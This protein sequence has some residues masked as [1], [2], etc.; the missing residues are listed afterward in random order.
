MLKEQEAAAPMLDN[1]IPKDIAAKNGDAPDPGA[2]F[3]QIAAL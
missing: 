2:W 1:A 3:V